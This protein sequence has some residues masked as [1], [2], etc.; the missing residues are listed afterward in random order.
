MPNLC[1]VD[2][3]VVPEA[4]AV[5]PVLD[6]GFLFGDSVYEVTRTHDGIPFAWRD[7]LDRLRGSAAGLGMEIAATDRELMGRVV[8]TVDAARSGPDADRECYVRVI[9]TRGTGTAP[10]IA[11]AHA[12]GPQRMVILVRPLVDHRPGRVTRLAIVPRLRN[13]RRALD[14]AIKSGNYLNN[15]LGLAEAQRQGADD[16]LFLNTDGRITEASTA[17]AWLVDATGRVVTP[18]LTAGLLAGITRRIVLRAAAAAGLTVAE[19]DLTPDDVATAREAF[20]SATLRDVAPVSHIDGR[21]L[22][23][24]APGP[25]TTRLIDAFEGEAAAQSRANAAGLAE[26]LA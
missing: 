17:N 16:C 10:N 8:A 19:V 14:P 21:A 11:L 26:L 25:I 18:P 7:H 23:D 3:T 12:P 15:V 24:G 5:V 1:N 6:R 2:G 22:P 20:L 13:D 4:E 9:V